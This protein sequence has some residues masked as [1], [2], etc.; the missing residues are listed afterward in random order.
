MLAI[1]RERHFH[2]VSTL[3]SVSPSTNM[4]LLIR[5]KRFTVSFDWLSPGEIELEHEKYTYAKRSIPSS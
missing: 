5:L 1:L 2:F 3:L 4:A